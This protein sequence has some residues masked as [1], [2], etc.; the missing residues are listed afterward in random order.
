M[1]TDMDKDIKDLRVL[2]SEEEIQKKLKTL[3]NEI[4]KVFTVDE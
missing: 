2:I 4:E 1:T 3:A